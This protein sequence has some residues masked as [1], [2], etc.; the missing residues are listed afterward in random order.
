MDDGP[1]SHPEL[2]RG[3]SPAFTSA[4]L[5]TRA[6][7]RRLSAEQWRPWNSEQTTGSQT[8]G[9]AQESS[10]SGELRL[11][12]SGPASDEGKMS[13][14]RHPALFSRHFLAFLGPII[15]SVCI[16]YDN[17]LVHGSELAI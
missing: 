16:L 14:Y 13:L 12:S 3:D 17:K 15:M 1:Q 7:K 11:E 5:S 2:G 8:V 9:T 6:R 10:E 4:Y